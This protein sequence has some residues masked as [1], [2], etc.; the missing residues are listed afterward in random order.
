MILYA[1]R[2]APEVVADCIT[3]KTAG[4]RAIQVPGALHSDI[5]LMEQTF[6]AIQDQVRE[7]YGSG[8]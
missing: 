6:S 7:W 4:V 8:A 1:E 3:L 5:F 2:D